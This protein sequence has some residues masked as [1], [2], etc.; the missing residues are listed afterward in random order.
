MYVYLL[1]YNYKQLLQHS[2]AIGH[3]VFLI[4][5][6]EIP[7]A[8]VFQLHKIVSLKYTNTDTHL[9]NYCNSSCVKVEGFDSLK[10]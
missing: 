4:L 1:I 2:L 10:F 3:K 8:G 9:N 5:V 6:T 7:K